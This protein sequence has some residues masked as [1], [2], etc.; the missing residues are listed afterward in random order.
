MTENFKTFKDKVNQIAVDFIQENYPKESGFFV[1]FWESFATNMDR[2]QSVAPENWPIAEGT[3]KAATELGFSDF[4]SM[5]LVTPIVICTV[6]K[7]LIKTRGESLSTSELKTV[8]GQAASNC[9]ASGQLLAQLMCHLPQL[10]VAVQAAKLDVKQAFV[11]IAKKPQYEIWADGEPPRIVRDISTYKTRENEF[12]FWVDI[13]NGEYKSL[14]KEKDLQPTT[15][16]LLLFLVE[17]IG[18]SLTFRKVYEEVIG[19]DPEGLENWRNLLTQY[20]GKLH[21]FAEESFRKSYLFHEAIYDTLCLK[22]SFRD[23]YF[24]F[25]TL[26]SPE[27]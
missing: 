10:C 20:I 14:G 11:S 5:D 25:R 27:E 15:T 12:L 24:V 18:V 26:R 9:G 1:A 21:K 4:K 3:R 23:K 17:N 19:I 2:W 22:D 16:R 7:V 13:T 8:V 6:A